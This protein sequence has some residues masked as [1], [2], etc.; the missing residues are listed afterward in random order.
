M[1]R[2]F[3]LI[4]AFA[5]CAPVLAADR[6]SEADIFGGTS[7][8]TATAT[9]SS[10]DTDEMAGSSHNLLAKTAENTQIGGTISTQADYY[11]KN[12][13]PL[14]QDT[15]TN[16][17]ILFLYLDSKLENDNRVFARIRAFYD[18]TGVSSGSPTANS[19]TNPYG[20]GNGTSDNLNVS[21]Q[22]LRIST[23]LDHKVF[24]TLGRQKVKYGAGKFFNP[25]DFL[26]SQPF[27]FFL[28]SDERPGVDMVKM[29]IPS[30]TANL[31][32][33]GLTGNPT[34]GNPAG[35][36]FRGE[37]AYNG[38]GDFL[39]AGEISLSGY[40]PKG[41]SGRGGFDISQGVG[42]LDVYFEGAAGQNSSGN[43]QGAFSTGGSWQTKYGDRQTETVSFEGEYSQ[44]PIPSQ[45]TGFTTYTSTQFGVFAVVL[46]GPGGLTDITFVETNLYD[47][48]G[49]SGFSRMDTVCQFT[50]RI[51]GRVYVSAPWG[52]AGG[53]FNPTNLL[54]QTGVRL[55]VNF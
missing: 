53:T 23:N 27:N 20:F 3:I 28:P 24:F 54:A 49:Q 9:P 48:N 6:P 44:Y 5:L 39:E 52:P 26:N 42:D 35:G 15:V 29:Q 36:Y 50:E 34:Y 8:A 45:T 11:L 25:T 19:Y 55:D 2:L 51:S 18:P 10:K 7:S 16:P 40:L 31:Y 1:N 30:G 21:L 46:S 22:E 4:S 17:N 14:D 41:Q 13:V 33:V 37:A 47:F 43:W 32:A 38:L 12:G